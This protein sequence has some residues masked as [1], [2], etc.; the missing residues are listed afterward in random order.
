MKIRFSCDVVDEIQQTEN[1]VFKNFLQSAQLQKSK[2]DSF[3]VPF[4]FGLILFVE[5]RKEPILVEHLKS[6]PL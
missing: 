4:I 3:P 5:V 6:T 1:N 2:L